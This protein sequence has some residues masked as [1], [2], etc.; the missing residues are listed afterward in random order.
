MSNNTGKVVDPVEP[1][2]RETLLRDR[3]RQRSKAKSNK[4]APAAIK[5]APQEPAELSPNQRPLWVDYRMFPERRMSWIIRG[6][7]LDGVVDAARLAD[8]LLLLR[9]RHWYLSC[10]IDKEGKVHPRDVEIPLEIK[11]LAADP[12]EQAL[13]Y[14][15]TE[16]PPF[17]LEQGELFRVILFQGEDCSVAVFAIHHIL[18]DQRSIDVLIEELS[19]LFADDAQELAPPPDLMQ[20]Y[21]DQR[22]A[23]NEN[24][25][26]LLR[27]W[28][29]RLEQ[30]PTSVPLPLAK[31]GFDPTEREGALVRSRSVP[32]L[33]ERCRSAAMEAGVSPYQWFLSAWYVLLCLYQNKDD[34]HLG[35]MCS[36]RIGAHQKDALGCF[37]NVVIVHAD[38]KGTETF[39][40]VLAAM[41]SVTGDAV[42]H[43]GLP[44]DEVARLAPA[45]SRG[46]LFSTLFTM[47]DARRQ[48][49]LLE[50]NV[51]RV[52]EL[53]YGGAAFDFTFFVNTSKNDLSFAI[54]FNTA[55]Y[56]R[57]SVTVLFNHFETL[58]TQLAGNPQL[59]WRRCRLMDEQ[60]IAQLKSEWH[61]IAAT[62]QS[63]QR[64]Y[65]AF[66]QQAN[67]NPDSVALRWQAD[68]A[69]QQTS[70]REL[71]DRSDAIAGFVNSM[72]EDDDTL[73]A[74]MG[75]WHPD[76][77]AA[78]IGVLRS[79]RAYLPIDADYPKA[80]VSQILRD[81]GTPLVLMQKN[82]QAPEDSSGRCYSIVDAVNS[83][84]AP[85]V[86]KS[87]PI[88]YVI[89]TS[90]SSGKPKGVRVSHDAA[91][92]STSE[93]STVYADWPPERFLLLSSFAFDSAVAGLWW[94]LSTGGCLQLVDR[95]TVQAADAVADLIRR[96]DI[97]HTLCL[98][99]QW[100]DIC[101]I[102]QCALSSMQLVIVAGEACSS[103]TIRNHFQCAP[104]AALYN[105]Y[106]PT[107][108]AVWSTFH[109][110]HSDDDDPVPIG[111]PLAL[112]QALVADRFGNLVPDGLSG[113]LLLSGHG[114]ADGYIGI[115]QEGFIAHP[116]DSKSRAYRT[117]DWVRRGADGL[118]YYLGRVDEQV[119]YRGYRI[120]IESIEQALSENGEEVA[121]IPWDGTTLEA[122]L[123]QLPEDQAHE[124]V[125]RRLESKEASKPSRQ[126]LSKEADQFRLNMELDPQFITPPRPAQRAWLLRKAMNELAEDLTALDQLAGRFVSGQERVETD[127]FKTQALS[128][129]S[130]SAIMEDWQ[131]PIM[132]AMAGIVGRHGGN[133]LEIGF[134]R[135]ISAEF[136]QEY[137]VERHTIVESESG[138][139]ERY[140]HPWRKKHG[141]ANI[142]LQIGK[143]QDCEFSPESFDGI[144]FHAYPLDETEFFEH[145]VKSVTYAEHAIPAMAGLLRAGGR[146]TYLTNEID[147]LSRTHQRLL[148]RYF[149]QIKIEV[150]DIDVPEDTKDAWWAP[151]MV[152]IECVR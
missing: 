45:R 62:P 17:R 104:D 59:L 94:T 137:E 67:Q 143:W 81:A 32:H 134:G 29:S 46:Q 109:R 106:G 96:E 53:D 88:A 148:F 131:I 41:R 144:L 119:K 50:R 138:V 111:Q 63:Q 56:D 75:A 47:L 21:E 83:T 20:A 130:D 65:D 120:G 151:Q 10:A 27:F 78:I 129:P 86:A 98:P 85:G 105:E 101:R 100:N 15:R 84:H 141:K 36:T 135:G 6:Y 126:R 55:L 122:L 124:L 113:E 14:C 40:D 54:E 9:Q 118:I 5:A 23:L 140:F 73:V 7:E 117:G 72:T 60:E 4:G 34:V 150:I 61:R 146:F 25:P 48:S 76:T 80:R 19:S 114:I 49:Q 43:G 64:L 95:R 74:V 103:N 3:L 33:A 35:T 90:G 11:S 125:D 39:T 68:G 93:R 136:I 70:Y 30:L 1:S 97:T 92:Y 26:E 102:S 66:Y 121:V 13:K 91:V 37:Q 147:S 139:V 127:D 123:A 149:S 99:S 132:R 116:V 44:L 115:S 28:R 71:A 24:R 77:V 51:L 128:E 31:Q 18:A 69:V 38:L 89:F 107:E 8:A 79:G 142:D 42:A 87:N 152:I 108:M 2:A 133:V 16:M 12:W 22:S 82:M 110:L 112:T 52:E 57:E 145:I 58:L